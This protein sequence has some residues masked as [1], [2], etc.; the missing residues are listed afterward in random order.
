M[1]L[2]LCGVAMLCVVQCTCNMRVLA[3]SVELAGVMGP[4]STHFNLYCHA[5]FAISCML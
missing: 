5:L 2:L 3:R 1:L 4:T